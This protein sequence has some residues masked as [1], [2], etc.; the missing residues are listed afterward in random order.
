MKITIITEKEQIVPL[1]VDINE[2]IE[3]VKAL[4]EV[5]VNIIYNNI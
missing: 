5:E 4:I 3:N 2:S 1:D